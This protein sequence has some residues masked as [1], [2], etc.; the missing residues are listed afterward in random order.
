[1][2]RPQAQDRDLRM[3]D[4]RRGAVDAEDA[5]VVHRE[6]P[7]GEV[8]G[9]EAARPGGSGLPPKRARPVGAPASDRGV[10]DDGYDQASLG[11][12]GKAQV[13]VSGNDD[14]VALD[15]RVQFGVTAHSQG[16]PGHHREQADRGPRC[17]RGQFG[18]RGQQGRVRVH[19]DPVASGI[20]RRERVSFSAAA[21]RVPRSGSGP[22]R[23]AGP[24]RRSPGSRRGAAPGPAGQCRPRGP[25][26]ARP[27]G[28]ACGRS[29]R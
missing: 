7:A 26:P 22:R 4:D 19:P 1:M 27:G 18:P 12:R 28:R 20:S 23:W 3:V 11:L 29:V 15:V 16:E 10:P 6:R 8:G 21:F 24:G 5:V 13:H 17:L 2:I 25:G 14:L 9:G